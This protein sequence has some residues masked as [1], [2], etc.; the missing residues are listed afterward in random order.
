MKEA[1]DMAKQAGAAYTVDALGRPRVFML[2]PFE[3]QKMIGLVRESCAQ[4]CDTAAASWKDADHRLAA[5]ILAH[6]IRAMGKK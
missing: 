3:L 2:S 5:T 4:H 1:I 6:G